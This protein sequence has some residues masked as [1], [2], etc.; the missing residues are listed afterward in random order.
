MNEPPPSSGQNRRPLARQFALNF[1]AG[2]GSAALARTLVAPIDRCKLLLQ[3][4]HAQRTIDPADRYRGIGDAF[5]RVVREQ[6]VWALWRG[7]AVNVARILP[8]QAL[9]FAFKDIFKVAFFRVCGAAATVARFVHRAR[10]PLF[11]G[12]R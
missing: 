12:F 5:R 2:G 11:A 1:V 8:I 4:Q 7:N 3:N 9:N 10:R 6:G